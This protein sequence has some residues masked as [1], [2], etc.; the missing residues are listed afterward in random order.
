MGYKGAA[1]ARQ[2]YIDNPRIDYHQMVADMC[3]EV[4]GVPI[5]RKN[6]KNL[7]LGMAYGMGIPKL[8]RSLGL[9]ISEA[10]PMFD[11]Y[12]A[13]VPYV[14]ELGKFSTRRAARKG[15]VHTALGRRRHFPGGEYTH[16]AL[17]SVIQGTSAD[18]MKMAIVALHEE[19]FRLYNNVH[20]E[21]D[22]PIPFTK[23]HDECIIDSVYASRMEEIMVSVLPLTVPLVVDIEYGPSWGEVKEWQRAK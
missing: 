17:N 22:A 6:A 18:M 3:L 5:G 1:E 4:T 15:F 9:E 13:S 14:K 8:A 19:G 23:V 21:I 20:D 11:A 7:N 12:H 2:R 16:K 10:Q